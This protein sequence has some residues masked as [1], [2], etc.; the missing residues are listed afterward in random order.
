HFQSRGYFDA[1]V[2]V[3]TQ[4]LANG[5][6]ILYD[7]TKGPR[8]RVKGVDIAGNQ[9]LKEEDLRPQVQVKRARIFSRGRYSESLVHTSVKNLERVYQANGFSDAKV[10]PEVRN[11]GGNIRVT[12]RV[13]EGERDLVEAMHVEGNDTQPLSVLAP[14]GLN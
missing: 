14:K 1:K 2:N 10:T 5:Q 4:A 12:F 13:A 9:T 7:I 6:T 11:E 8:H 3:T